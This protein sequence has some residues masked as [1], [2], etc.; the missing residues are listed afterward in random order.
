[1]KFKCFFTVTL[2]MSV[3]LVLT[4][5]SEGIASEIEPLQKFEAAEYNT[6]A[7][8]CCFIDWGTSGWFDKGASFPSG[9]VYDSDTGKKV[10]ISDLIKKRPIIIAIGSITCPAYDVNIKY[11]NKLKIKYKNKIDF[12]TLYTRE[13]H[14]GPQFP[15]H[16]TLEQKIKFAKIMKKADKIYHNML[17]DSI[18]GELHQKL[19]NF[20]NSIYLIGTDMKIAYW[21]IFNSPPLL[22]KAMI[23]LLKAKGIGANSEMV[24]GTHIHP[25]VNEALY[26]K[27]EIQSTKLKMANREGLSTN[28]PNQKK[29][30][31]S[32]VLLK[33]QKDS[34]LSGLYN[35][36][37]TPLKK[38]HQTLVEYS[39]NPDKKDGQVMLGTYLKDLV[40]NFKEVYEVR[41]VEWAKK[42][43]IP[44]V[45]SN[46]QAFWSE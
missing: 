4:A 18:D 26:S 32:D 31:A 15:A 1:M 42:N 38:S 14:P 30:T 10:Q 28:D 23:N 7:N 33:I 29:D 46:K 43:N 12:Y 16:S 44:I 3:F 22:E 41:Y 34:K 13:N 21:S 8:Y 27:S 20:G 11:L 25:M 36:L 39:M 37:S 40:K 17:V 19:G 9:E 2:I 24:A 6:N 45:E 35:Q 5:A